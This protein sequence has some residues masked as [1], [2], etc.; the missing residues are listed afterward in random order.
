MAGLDPDPS[1]RPLID[2]LQPEHINFNALEEIAIEH[3]ASRVWQGGVPARDIVFRGTFVVSTLFCFRTDSDSPPFQF[4]MKF[5]L[6]AF[7]AS[8]FLSNLASAQEVP[9]KTGLPIPGEA[10]AV[11]GRQAFLIPSEKA[12]AD[13]PK[14]WVWYAPTLNGL[15]GRAEQWMF[16]KFLAAGISIAG[17]D[18]GESYGSPDGRKFFTDLYSELTSKR[19]YSAKPVLLARSRGG[20]MTLAWAA[21]NAEKVAAW[22]GIYPVSNI[23]SYPGIARAATSYHLTEAQL[24]ETLSLHNPIDRLK[25]LAEA[26]VPFFAIHGDADKLVPLEKN[27]A[28]LSERYSAL[29]APMQLIVSPG[30]G[31]NMWP[32]FF[33]SEELVAFVKKHAAP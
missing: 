9:Q 33:E 24:T 4:M 12:P 5:P 8:T 6:A 11:S 21:E 17:I 29:K 10:F 19:G 26:A 30:Q 7:L 27:S 2:C 31:H 14:P 13:R 16:E 3:F 23:A 15:P 25:L 22:A 18:V 28:I 1:R 32:G 20:L